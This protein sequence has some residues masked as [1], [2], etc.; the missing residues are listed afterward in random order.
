MKRT[1]ELDPALVEEAVGLALR[2]RG[3]SDPGLLDVWHA[4]VDPVY[5]VAPAARE[6]AFAALHGR[7]FERLGFESLV[8]TALAGHRDTVAR[9]PALALLRAARGDDEGA[10]LGAPGPAG[11]PA[12]IRVAAARFADGATLLPFLDRELTRLADLVDPAFGHVPDDLDTIPA[13]RRRLVQRRYRQAWAASLDGRIARLGRV[14]LAGRGAHERALAETFPA[15]AG[16]GLRRLAQA[17]WSGPRPS[18]AELFAL[19]SAHAAAPASAPGA[20]CPLC[21]FPTHAWAKPGAAGVAEAIR[22]DVPGWREDDGLC[23]RCLERYAAHSTT[24]T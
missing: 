6:A 7:W 12:A 13:H 14:P 4:E 20:P 11:R 1:V 22:R 17:L 10:D 18:H 9:L 21:G 19:A 16:A 24:A 23:D 3:E 8:T 5:R 15:M 2:R